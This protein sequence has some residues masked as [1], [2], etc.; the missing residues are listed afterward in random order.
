MTNRFGCSLLTALL[1]LL[2]FKRSYAGSITG[3]VKFVGDPP[4]LPSVQVTKDQDYCG[5]TL[6]NEVYEIG[7][8]K[9]LKNV[10]VF[11]D[12]APTA[13][14]DPEKEHVLENTGCRFTPRIL[15]MQRGEKLRVTNKDRK[16][17]IA[18]S[19]L[20]EKTVFNVALPFKGTSLDVTRRLTQPGMLKVVCDT[21]S[22]MLAYIHIFDNPYF[23]VTDE[24]GWFSIPNIPP[25][26][27]V[28]T[29]WHEDGGLRHQEIMVSDTDDIRATFEFTRK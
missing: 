16:L 18:H 13:A 6:P 23:T 11:I 10:V 3:E 14:A 2:I 7:V 20:G 28:L 8:N 15:T 21:H 4:H 22:W 9:G 5:E 17:H 24:R 25:G 19:Y 12:S 26:R 27:Y 29:A 1:L